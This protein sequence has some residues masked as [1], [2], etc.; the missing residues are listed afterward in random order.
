MIESIN[1][2]DKIIEKNK[3]NYDTIKVKKKPI[4]LNNNQLLTYLKYR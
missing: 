3:D 4:K 2:E 1:S